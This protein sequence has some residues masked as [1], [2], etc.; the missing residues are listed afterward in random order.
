MIFASEVG[1]ARLPPKDIVAKGRL[2]PARMLLID[3]KEGRIVDDEEIKNKA[4]S[5]APFRTWLDEELTTL[6]YVVDTARKMGEWRVWWEG[7]GGWEG[8]A[9]QQDRRLFAFG[10]TM[11]QL[12]M[13]LIPMACLLPSLLNDI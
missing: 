11:E 9:L 4:A 2:Q 6:D 10:Y 8:K 7:G 12:N 1:T 5:R 13:L 3:T